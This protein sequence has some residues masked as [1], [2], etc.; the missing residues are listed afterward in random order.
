MV[1]IPKTDSL[2]ATNVLATKNTPI[3]GLM[4][5]KGSSTRVVFLVILALCFLT[6][7]SVIIDTRLE[8]LTLEIVKER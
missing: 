7:Q 6:S 8:E 2:T 4:L 1:S 3:F 5:P